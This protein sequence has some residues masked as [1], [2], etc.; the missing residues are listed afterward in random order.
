[1]AVK[2][3]TR[4]RNMLLLEGTIGQDAQPK[5]TA[6]GLDLVRFSMCTNQGFMK[7]GVWKD[8]LSWHNIVAFAP[9]SEVAKTLKKGDRVLLIGELSYYAHKD[10][11]KLML[12]QIKPITIAVT[13][14]KADRIGLDLT[15]EDPESPASSDDDIPW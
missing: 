1:M 10:N 5:T 9:Q 3:I 13:R 11:N 6:T 8:N 4:D 7:D 14:R 12:P 15:K 2:T